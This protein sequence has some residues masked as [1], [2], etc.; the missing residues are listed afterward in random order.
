MTRMGM[1]LTLAGLT[2]SLCYGGDGVQSNYYVQAANEVIYVIRGTDVVDSF[3]S[4]NDGSGPLYV[5]G[6]SVCST[7]SNM[8]TGGCYSLEGVPNGHVFSN[9]GIGIAI[10]R[11][12]A[13]DGER[14]FVFSVLSQD[15]NTA[16]QDFD[17]LAAIINLPNPGT[18]PFIGIAYD[19]TDNTLWL[20]GNNIPEIRQYDL[21]G[22]LIQSFPIA[23]HPAG[24]LAFDPADQTLWF[25]HNPSGTLYQYSRSGE[26]LDSFVP[27]GLPSGQQYNGGDINLAVSVPCPGDFNGDGQ[28]NFFDVSDFLKAFNKGC[29]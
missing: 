23:A 19:P 1:T 13:T 29:P 7:D 8:L 5:Y 3:P 27:T 10:V 15:V 18:Y 6:D 12:A 28:L 4:L 26:L 20:S 14:V 22:I 25:I 16:D 9:P 2:A 11:D 17:D 24:A 21:D